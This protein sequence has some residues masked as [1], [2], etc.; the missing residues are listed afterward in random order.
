METWG[1]FKDHGLDLEA[2]GNPLSDDF[3][4]LEH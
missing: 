2:N 1:P 4:F 3:L